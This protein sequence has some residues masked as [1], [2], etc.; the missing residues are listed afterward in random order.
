LQFLAPVTRDR[1]VRWAFLA[2]LAACGE[3][4]LPDGY[5]GGGDLGACKV[6][7]ADNAWNTDVSAA[8]VDPDSERYLAAMGSSDHFLHPDFG[9]DRDHGI[10]FVVVPGSQPKVPVAFR[11]ANESDPGPYPIPGNAPVEAGGDHHVLVIEKDSC[12][13][14]EMFQAR[15]EGE[16]W[17]AWAGATFDLRSNRL[18]PDGWTSADAAG[19]PIFAGLVRYDE[20]KR[21]EIRHALRF[22]HERT[23]KEYVPPATHSAA[24]SENRWAAPMG[25]RVR[26]KA[27]F[28]VA[29]FSPPVRVILAALKRYGMFLADNGGD[30]FLSGA[31]DP[32]WND[33]ELADLYL[34]PASAFEVVKLAR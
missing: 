8:P 29:S 1:D 17:F 23:A 3:I 24:T 4:E 12:T 27:S 7:P 22:T 21:G 31:P 6:F 20:V 11:W 16:G 32:R 25:M 9:A 13:L 15:R 5:Y 18:R 28:E 2:V 14:Y 33:R 10:P 19:L 30:W 34:V 26:L